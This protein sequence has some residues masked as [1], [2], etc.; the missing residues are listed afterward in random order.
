[1]NIKKL[2]MMERV[3]KIAICSQDKKWM[4]WKYRMKKKIWME[5]KME[6]EMIKWRL[7]VK[8]IEIKDL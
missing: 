8:M 5:M 4:K 1:M 6:K 7:K 2:K 3:K